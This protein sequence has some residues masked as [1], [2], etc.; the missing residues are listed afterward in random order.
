MIGEVLKNFRLKL[1]IVPNS[2]SSFSTDSYL[3]SMGFDFSQYGKRKYTNDSFKIEKED[4]NN[5]FDITGNEKILPEL[6]VTQNKFKMLMEVLKKFL[7][8]KTIG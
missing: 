6:I 8:Q 5:F 4:F 2:F 3:L 7:F 1:N